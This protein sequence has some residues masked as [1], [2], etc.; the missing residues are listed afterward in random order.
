VSN[1]DSLLP[2]ACPDCDLLQ[3][4]PPLRAGGR[5]NCTRC[6]RLLAKEPGSLD[7]PLALTIAAAIAL[8]V[9]NVLPLMELKVAGRTA[10][11]T[12]AGGAYEIWLNGEHLTG[13]LVAFCAVVAP[14]GYLLLMLALLLAGRHTPV[15]RW[16]GE[17]LRW[18]QHLQVWSML[19]VV[20][21]GILVALVKIAQL[22]TVDPG[23][24][25]Y[26]FALVVVLIPMIAGSFDVRDLWRRVEW[27]DGEEKAQL[28]SAGAIGGTAT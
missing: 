25:I 18:M 19:E 14:A 2:V 10:S 4:V 11:T 20:M 7:R 23:I 15:P 21:L 22:A 12:I 1:T 17:V 26:A 9:A 28:P 16:V 8:I 13:V 24:G 6:G 3:R 27:D 5:A